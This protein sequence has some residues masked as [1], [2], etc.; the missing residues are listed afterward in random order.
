[1]SAGWLGDLGDGGGLAIVVVIGAG[2]DEQR[3]SSRL[4]MIDAG[5]RVLFTPFS[6]AIDDGS[7]W[8]AMV[9]CA[10]FLVLTGYG[11]SK[12]VMGM[13]VMGNKRERVWG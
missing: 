11:G 12:Q 5:G 2:E 9:R 3:C 10:P 1:R 8:K 6:A 4:V 7:G 13:M